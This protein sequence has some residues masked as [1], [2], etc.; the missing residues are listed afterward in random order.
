M[1]SIV[2]ALIF[3]CVFKGTHVC[4]PKDGIDLC[5]VSK[6]E[7]DLSINNF[8]QS[9]YLLINCSVLII[10]IQTGKSKSFNS[11]FIACFYV[12]FLV[13]ALQAVMQMTGTVL[14]DSLFRN[15][16]SNPPVEITTAPLRNPGLF[17]EP[18]MA[19]VVA[20]SYWTYFYICN[21][22]YG[23]YIREVVLSLF[24]VVLICSSGSLLSLAI[25]FVAPL[26][27][28]HPFV[29]PT[30]LNIL[31]L[32]RRLMLIVPVLVGVTLIMLVPSVNR[33]I[34]TFTFEK[35]DSGSFM[36]RT[37]SDLFTLEILKNTHYMGVGFGSN[38]PSSLIA[39]LLSN[40]G[41]AGFVL[42]CAMVVSVA[43]SSKGHEYIW[44]VIGCIMN[45]AIDVPDLT[46][47]YIW[48]V[49]VACIFSST[50]GMCAVASDLAPKMR[51][52]YT[53]GVRR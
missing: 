14:P 8:V 26:L 38:R 5:L 36:A 31:H 41:V 44:L 13:V 19:G 22:K 12:L 17:S 21:L 43:K 25:L 29:S 35:G 28:Y 30:R 34:F 9:A 11:A 16:P 49:L 7:L 15:N 32:K 39:Y 46:F 1:Y 37:A 48:I 27:V 51:T 18:S 3:P 33:L 6:A 45:A 52:L 40:V 42:F 50:N 4:D 53:Q 47:S 10:A 2:T 23:I 20:V 24:L